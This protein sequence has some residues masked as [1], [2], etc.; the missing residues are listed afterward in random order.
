MVAASNEYVLCRGEVLRQDIVRF[1]T[2]AP[3]DSG[4][5]TTSFSRNTSDRT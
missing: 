2:G 3:D 1:L 4:R 5:A